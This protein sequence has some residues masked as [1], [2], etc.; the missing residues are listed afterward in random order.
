MA[1]KI[2]FFIISL[3]VI[4]RKQDVR[5]LPKQHYLAPHPWKSKLRNHA[6]DD[7]ALA[8]ADQ[9]MPGM[10][11]W[12]EGCRRFVPVYQLSRVRGI[13]SALA[14]EQ[15][16]KSQGIREFAMKPKQR[17]CRADPQG[18]GC[19]LIKFQPDR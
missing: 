15:K 18:S 1:S 19:L 10:S 7:F 3:L 16:A 11:L 13:Y 2:S 8:I 4:R 6:L 17:D 9:T 12:R 14:D 5:V